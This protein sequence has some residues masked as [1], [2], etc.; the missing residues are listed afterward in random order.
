[1]VLKLEAL[2]VHWGPWPNRYSDEPP[3][4]MVRL[5]ATLSRLRCTTRGKLQLVNHD[6]CLGCYALDLGMRFMFG[7]LG[8]IAKYSIPSCSSI[9]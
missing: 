9:S 3:A 8:G 1:M 7:V 4:S 6:L 5:V 2:V